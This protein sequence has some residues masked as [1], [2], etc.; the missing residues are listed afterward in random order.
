MAQTF[1]PLPVDRVIFGAGA[2]S[3]LPPAVELTAAL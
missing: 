2:L 3:E 1:V